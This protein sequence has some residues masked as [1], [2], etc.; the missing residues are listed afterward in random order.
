MA[1]TKQPAPQK[2]END[3]SPATGAQNT[4]G[5]T[6]DTELASAVAAQIE[7]T[8]GKPVDPTPAPTPGDTVDL[9]ANPEDKAGEKARQTAKNNGADADTP[10]KRANGGAAGNR[11]DDEPARRDRQ[12]A[13]GR[14]QEDDPRYGRQVRRDEDQRNL[15]GDEDGGYYDRRPR[16]QN[17]NRDEDYD[18][19]RRA[20]QGYGHTEARDDNERMSR[21][22]GSDYRRYSDAGY[23]DRNPYRS[24]DRAY[25]DQSSYGDRDRIYN[26]GGQYRPRPQGF[27]PNDNGRDF[28]REAREQPR[29]RWRESNVDPR[30]DEA[31]DNHR[32]SESRNRPWSSQGN[33]DRY[34]DQDRDEGRYRSQGRG[35]DAPDDRAREDSRRREPVG[36]DRPSYQAPREADRGN[37]G[38]WRDERRDDRENEAR[39]RYEYDRTPPR[40][41]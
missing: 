3:D 15:F 23:D 4:G 6:D 18:R 13:Q 14:Q 20:A 35:Y 40:R 33:Q 9:D 10:R 5:S 19:G 2:P 17:L 37:T 28:D 21:D 36:G 30:Y 31:Y 38:R 24:R 27:R 22:Y 41:R 25:D 26:E 34:R 39:D 11:G 12:V 32:N 29:N 16:Q 7:Q 8:T 1:Q